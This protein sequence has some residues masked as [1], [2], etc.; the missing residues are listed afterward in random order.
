MITIQKVTIGNNGDA[1]V[2]IPEYYMDIDLHGL[3]TDDTIADVRKSFMTAFAEIT[4]EP[5][6]YCYMT[7][8]SSLDTVIEEP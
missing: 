7:Y 6:D 8:H 3:D 2:G 4:G 5:A 1:S